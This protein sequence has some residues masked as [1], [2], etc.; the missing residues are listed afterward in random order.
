MG[1][2]AGTPGKAIYPTCAHQLLRTHSERG[3]AQSLSQ[4]LTCRARS[5]HARRC[6]SL[7]G[8]LALGNNGVGPQYRHGPRRHTRSAWE[9]EFFIDKLLVRIHLYHPCDDVD[10][11]GTMGVRTLFSIYLPSV[12]RG[13]K[14]WAT[15]L[16]WN[17]EDSAKDR[18]GTLAFKCRKCGGFIYTE[19][20]HL[21]GGF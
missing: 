9:R 4:P 1:G 5:H 21:R 7:A 15:I 14:L 20:L 13:P 19:A 12:R 3:C 17:I 8:T 10:R 11:P 2:R 16:M 6:D 18:G